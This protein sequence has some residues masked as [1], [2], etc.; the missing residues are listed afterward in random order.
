M[1]PQGR[2]YTTLQLSL[3]TIKVNRGSP[4]ASVIPELIDKSDHHFCQIVISDLKTI[5]SRSRHHSS[6]T[7]ST[8]KEGYNLQGG[9]FL[10]TE[11]G[12]AMNILHTQTSY[13]IELLAQEKME[14]LFHARCFTILG[15][16]NQGN[17]LRGGDNFFI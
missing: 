6:E 3:S 9:E 1:E 4:R 13:S 14:L 7:L 10:T 12:F 5:N 11:G 15:Y 8:V 16:S 17:V 2:G